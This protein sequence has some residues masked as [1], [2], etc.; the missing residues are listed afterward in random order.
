VE[1]GAAAAPPVVL[2]AGWGCSAYLYRKNLQPLADAG[3]RAI[4]VELK[5]Q[6]E[7]DKPLG[8]GEYTLESL[9]EHTLEIL[10]ALALPS[11]MLVGLSLGGAIATRVALR[12]PERV[13][14]LALL[15]SVG[16]GPVRFAPFARYFPASIGA[17]LP[18]LTR[19]W[20]FGVALRAAY[21]T[22]GAPTEHDVDAYFAP[23]RDPAF[24]RTLWA[25][26]REVEWRELTP[27][28][29]RRLSM[30]TLAVVGTHDRVISPHRVE[31][32][33]REAPHARIARIPGAGH[34]I[35]EEAPEAVN[36]LL[37]DFLAA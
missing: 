21:G 11:V 8:I 4:A 13:R 1:A 10:D 33:L 37:V 5:G 24:V 29:V 26:L 14:K 34:A 6:G 15:A 30:P 2:L 32:V 31:A 23:A 20:M 27:P 28:E 35:A 25:L 12:A 9:A 36:R 22:L 7:S 3:F 16:L 18:P 19:R 17:L